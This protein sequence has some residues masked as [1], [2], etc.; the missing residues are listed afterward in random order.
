MGLRIKSDGWG[1]HVIH[2]RCTK[3]PVSALLPRIGRVASNA[4]GYTAIHSTTIR[5]DGTINSTDEQDLFCTNNSSIHG[6]PNRRFRYLQTS[7]IC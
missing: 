2:W 4:N 1:S 3:Y 6:S 7:A 5:G